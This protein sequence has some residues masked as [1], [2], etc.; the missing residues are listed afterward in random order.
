MTTTMPTTEMTNPSS[1]R[2]PAGRVLP[3]ARLGGIGGLVFTAS[4]L[5]QNIL[6][7]SAPQNDATPEKIISWYGDHRGG[8]LALAVLFPIGAAG[9]AAF[10]ASLVAQARGAARAPAVIGGL[11]A[12][13]LVAMFG[14]VTATDLAL[15]T[16]V[17]RG[18]ADPSVVSALWLTHMS[19]FGVNL[20]FIGITLAALTTACTMMGLLRPIWQKVGF[21]GAAALAVGAACT[22]AILDA[23]AVLAI[24]MAGFLVW[25]VFVVAASISLLRKPATDRAHD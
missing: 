19:L 16:Y 3:A 4:I 5:V 10:V 7:A 8:S 9:I 6:R 15:S 21:V 2:A 23:S 1:T 17:H 20:V 24:P 18:A 22:P 25:G 14:V 12:A 11:S 13:S